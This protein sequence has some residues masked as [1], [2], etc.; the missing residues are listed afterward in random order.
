MNHMAGLSGLRMDGAGIYL[1]R[2]QG[3]LNSAWLEYEDDLTIIVTSPMG[4]G[5][6]STLCTHA[7]D[8]AALLGILNRLYTFG[9]PI[10]YLECVGI[11][12]A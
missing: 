5:P 2:V 11:G 7:A 3:N 1:I 9:Y 10:L 8:Q 4:L 12:A 6:V